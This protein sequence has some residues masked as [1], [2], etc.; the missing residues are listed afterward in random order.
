MDWILR[1]GEIAAVIALDASE[2]YTYW[3]KR[4]VDRQQVWSL[5][6]E[7]WAMGGDSEG[8]A[9]L[10]VWPH[11]RYAALCASDEWAGFNPRSI[12]L[13]DWMQKWLPGLTRDSRY[14][15]VFPTAKG[16]G[17]PVDPVR[18]KCDLKTEIAKYED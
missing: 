17:I 10:P 9:M 16:R 3:L 18:L 5:W 11:A 1:E 6:Q 2:R 7:G 4:V 14:V 12:T 15:S 13:E 8:R